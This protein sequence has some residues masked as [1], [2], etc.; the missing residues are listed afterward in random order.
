MCS[1]LLLPGVYKIAVKYIISDNIIQI[2]RITFKMKD[3][4]VKILGL[5]LMASLETFM[6]CELR[7]ENIIRTV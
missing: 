4:A 1:V 6:S 3:I 7:L 2:E 5:V